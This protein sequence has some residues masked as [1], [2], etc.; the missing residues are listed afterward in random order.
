[1]SLKLWAIHSLERFIALQLEFLA[2]WKL[3][4]ELAVVAQCSQGGTAR[5]MSISKTPVG[6]VKPSGNLAELGADN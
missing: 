5:S 6:L 1:M 2:K 3:R 4:A